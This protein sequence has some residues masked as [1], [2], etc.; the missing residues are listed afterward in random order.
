MCGII[1]YN[2]HDDAKEYLM[3][4]LKRLEY[5]GYDSAGIALL[6]G[7]DILWEK[8]KGKLINLEETVR[9][10]V[11]ILEGN[12]GIGHTRWAT[13]G[14]VTK[15]NAHPHLSQKGIFAVVHNGII[16]NYGILKEELIKEGYTFKSETDTEV[17]AQ[18]LEKYYSGSVISDISKVSSILKG[19][20]ALA[21][22]CKECSDKLFCVK[23][24]SPLIVGS[25]E[26]G[27]FISSDIYAVSQYCH[28]VYKLEEDE[29]AVLKPSSISFYAKDLS[30]IQKE[31]YKPTIE[32]QSA[33][34]ENFPHFMLKEIHEQP[35]AIRD[36]VRA[37][38][39]NEIKSKIDFDSINKICISACGSAYH[40][41]FM[42]KYIIESLCEISVETDISSEFR[43][44]QPVIGENTL[45]I[46]ISQSGETADS[47]GALRLAKE[48]RAKVLSIVN[49]PES[50]IARESDCVIYTQ[51]GP[52]I[53]VATTKAY[54]AQLVTI[55]LLG[56]HLGAYLKKIEADTRDL[57]LSQVAQLPEKMQEILDEESKVKELVPIFKDCDH[58]YFIGRNTDY[59]IALEASLK[60]KEISYIPCEAYGAG[61][62]KHGT[63]SLI[64]EGTVV[65]ALACNDSV[66]KKTESNIQEVKSRGGK[67][68]CFT[69]ERHKHE[70][71]DTDHVFLLPDFNNFFSGSLE[72]LPMQLLSYYIAKEKGCDIDKPRNLAKSVTVE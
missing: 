65:V 52:E 50:S 62:L 8:E 29:I 72:I 44:R 66:F 35:K 69:T 55:Y 3:T 20:F 53:A 9:E 63:L 38:D 21:I 1:G 46:I 61:E 5:R 19:S 47:L 18:L 48:K 51:A 10:K 37:F 17:I 23:R 41:G 34:K 68:I 33:D 40:V 67:V 49:V 54:S 11:D 58:I 7:R 57:F 45:V 12:I 24:G 31:S 27:N 56:I 4:G 13:H 71:R 2:G 25:G 42:G 70:I 32:F 6:K 36:T 64:E 60:M 39:F 26:K 28:S 59:A 30:P 15:E 16:E 22:I 43:Y 14:A